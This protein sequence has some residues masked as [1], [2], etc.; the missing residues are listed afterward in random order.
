MR[1]NIVRGVPFVPPR[2][3][4]DLPSTFNLIGTL[5]TYLSV[6]FLLPMFFAIGVGDAFWP[7][8]ASAAITLGVGLGAQA[9]TRGRDRVG[10]REGFLV[11]ALLWLLLPAFG[12]L[13]YFLAGEGSLEQP[14]DA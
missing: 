6:A 11:V 8:L 9:L 12:A 5:V 1:R 14:L 4:V 10:I 7:F 3:G 13:P 2:L